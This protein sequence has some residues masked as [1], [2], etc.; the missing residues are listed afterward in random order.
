MEQ[1]IAVVSVLVVVPLAWALMWRGWRSRA[2]RQSG[3]PAPQAPPRPLEPGGAGVVEGVYVS[4]TEAGQPLERVVAHGL[5]MRSPVL[6]AVAPEGVVL[7]RRGAPSVLVPRADLLGVRR[8]RGMVGKFTVESEGLVVLTWR[9][10][11]AEL[12]TGVRCRRR[13]DADRLVAQVQDLLEGAR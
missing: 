10:G 8:S 2:R 9:L 1:L 7:E 3:V 5:G 4:T 12:D 11:A 6:V 13:A